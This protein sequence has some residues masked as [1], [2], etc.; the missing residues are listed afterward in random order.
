MKL[1]NNYHDNISI[2]DLGCQ[3]MS[4]KNINAKKKEYEVCEHNPLTDLKFGYSQ[5]FYHT[6][7]SIV[8]TTPVMVCPFGINSRGTNFKMCLQF[9][10]Y[11]SDPVMKSFYEFIQET[12]YKQMELLGLKED[13]SDLFLSQIKHDKLER[14]DPNLEIKIPF[15]YNKFT[16]DIFSD[17]YDGVGIM[18]ISK[19]SKLQCDIYLDKIWKYND[20]YISKWKVKMIYLL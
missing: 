8:V 10:N 18:N 17:N 11:M 6:K 14:Y 20:N 19:F 12:E 1:S 16:C 7:S 2:Q 9:T 15:S 13:T 5:L 3:H 4:C